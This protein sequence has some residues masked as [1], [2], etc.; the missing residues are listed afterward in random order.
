MPALDALP[1]L[2]LVI[3]SNGSPEMLQSAVRYN[4]LE[5]RFAQII[6]ADREKIY[7]FAGGILFM[8]GFVL[9]PDRISRLQYVRGLLDIRSRGTR[10]DLWC[11]S[12]FGRYSHRETSEGSKYRVPG[13]RRAAERQNGPAKFSF[14]IQV[15][16]SW[17]TRTLCVI[18]TCQC[19]DRRKCAKTIN[20][21]L[22][23]SLHLRW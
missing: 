16:S 23:K 12:I 18:T 10:L 13:V 17:P 15:S 19:G 20:R 3:L 2:P 8:L 4:H 21:M 11:R 6:L 5:S 7:K 22:D 14:P 9:A 1:R